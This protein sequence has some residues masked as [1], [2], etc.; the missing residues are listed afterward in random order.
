MASAE[1]LA[2]LP[3]RRLG[4]GLTVIEARGLRAWVT[5]LSGLAEL[6]AD[7]ALELRTPMIDTLAVRFP[8]DLLWLT[9]DG[10]VLRV[11]R[12]VRP[13]RIRACLRAR[14]VIECAAGRADAFL[15]A[16]DRER[17]ESRS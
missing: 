15:V 5:G 13:R 14:R 11:D 7:V 10:R 8:I 1:R 9:G 12:S 6:T 3:R 17:C 4:A 16:L 2:A